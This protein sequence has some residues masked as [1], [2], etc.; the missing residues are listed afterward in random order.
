MLCFVGFYQ[1]SKH[2]QFISSF[3]AWFCVHQALDPM[4][5]TLIISRGLK[6]GNRHNG[7][8]RAIV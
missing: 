1:R 2:I 6:G 8:D 4:Q 7:I 3:G 5:G